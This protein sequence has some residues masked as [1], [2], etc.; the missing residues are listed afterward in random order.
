MDVLKSYEQLP[1]IVQFTFLSSFPMCLF[2]YT[3]V[4]YLVPLHLM[5]DLFRGLGFEKYHLIILF[6]RLYACK[7]RFTG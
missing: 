2:S 6:Q 4:L 3:F 1:S 7:C 5:I